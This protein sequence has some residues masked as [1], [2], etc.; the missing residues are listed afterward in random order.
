MSSNPLQPELD[1]E[2]P[3]YSDDVDDLPLPDQADQDAA[4]AS[5]EV[6][7]E[8]V[9]HVF[10]DDEEMELANPVASDD[11]ADGAPESS[12]KP[13]PATQESAEKNQE[14]PTARPKPASDA[15]ETDSLV[16]PPEDDDL[17][18]KL[19]TSPSSVA[20][21]VTEWLA[22][23]QVNG[24]AA[25]A[26]VLSL[27]VRL[28]RPAGCPPLDLVTPQMVISNDPPSAVNDIAHVLRADVSGPVPAVGKDPV[29]RKLRRAYEDFWK[30]LAAKSTQVVLSIPTVSTHLFHGLRPWLS[31][32]PVR[33]GLR[34]AL[35]H[36]GW[37]MDSL[38]SVH[39]CESS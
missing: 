34:L 3:A 33:Y 1:S 13:A 36:I 27:V 8:D 31:P 11:E 15:M 7:P 38:T 10:D 6:E 2:Q 24:P 5:D 12:D 37:S 4:N 22:R 23:V 39:D 25:V 30:R 26:D 9:P 17:F 14:S 19:A 18:A 35:P 16:E 29:S 21:L 20:G 32:I 28:A